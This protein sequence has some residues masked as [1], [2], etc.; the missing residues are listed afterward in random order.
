MLKHLFTC[1]SLY[2][3]F[4]SVGRR[5]KVFQSPGTGII[6]GYEPL[7]VCWYLN[8]SL[9]QEHQLLLNTTQSLLPF[10]VNL[11]MPHNTPALKFKYIPMINHLNNDFI[12]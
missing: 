1:V 5:S 11:Y 12:N 4:P 2:Y 7:C 10:D 3:V 8:L 6:D 9:W